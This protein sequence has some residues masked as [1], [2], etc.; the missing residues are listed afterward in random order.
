VAKQ[1][2]TLPPSSLHIESQA[3][4]DEAEPAYVVQAQDI[5]ISAPASVAM[6]VEGLPM[7]WRR[8]L[9]A[10]NPEGTLDAL[11]LR[12]SGSDDF[13]VAASVDNMGWH[14]LDRPGVI[15]LSGIVRGDQQR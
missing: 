13:D 7:P 9:Y 6:L 3:D 14:A 8:W 1:G 2:A 4:S 10:G 12:W 15:G 11:V 5:D